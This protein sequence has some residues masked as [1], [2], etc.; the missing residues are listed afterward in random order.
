MMLSSIKPRLADLLAGY[1]ASEHLGSVVSKSF[2]G[3]LDHRSRTV[4]GS[5]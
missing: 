1:D 4:L 5:T 2:E 3:L